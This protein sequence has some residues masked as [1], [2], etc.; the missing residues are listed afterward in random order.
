SK[1]AEPSSNLRHAATRAC[2]TAAGC[3]VPRPAGPQRSAPELRRVARVA[4]GSGPV[5]QRRRE[6]SVFSARFSRRD[7][8]RWKIYERVE[9]RSG[10]RGGAARGRARTLARALLVGVAVLAAVRLRA[11]SAAEQIGGEL[12]GAIG[13]LPR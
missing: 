6:S 12:L 8:A 1:S 3:G 5:T 13:L 10:L 4:F 11:R 9:F 2:T 7:P